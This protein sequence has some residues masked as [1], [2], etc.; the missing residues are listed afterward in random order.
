MFSSL[1]SLLLARSRQERVVK[2]T[3]TREGQIHG[4]QVAESPASIHKSH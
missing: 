3:T 1:A 4:V 2:G